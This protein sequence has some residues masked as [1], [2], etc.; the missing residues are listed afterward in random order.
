M[1]FP[2][3]A[4]LNHRFGAAGRIA[5]RTGKAGLPIVALV[6]SY[7][8][9]ETSLYGGQV[10][11][12]R[13]TGHVPVLFTSKQAVYEPGKPIRGGI[14][15]CWPWF[16]PNPDKALPQHG[17]ARILQWSLQATEYSSDVTELQLMLSDSELTRRYWPYAFELTLRVRLG[18]SLSITLT[19][20]NR[21]TRT[22]TLTQAIHPYFRVR[23]VRDVTVGGLDNA[24]YSDLLTRR[25]ATQKGVLNIRSETD[26]IYT[27]VS[28]ECALHDPG[29]GRVIA[30][31]YAGTKRLV[32]WNPWI[33]KAR[34]L[35]DFDDDEYARMLCIE[36]VNTEDDAVTLAPG[37]QHTLSLAVQATL[38]P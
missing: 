14:P 16:G 20:A 15:V 38:L 27:P 12:Y 23:Q 4:F 31:T 18:Q 17:F 13:P 9:C 32:V 6:N 36:P 26:R 2:D 28:L 19:T 29:L 24:P 21:D 22:F 33:D 8:S 10:L 7:G 3:I 30:L 25:S 11:E 5:F 1:N 34:A 35:S 37:E